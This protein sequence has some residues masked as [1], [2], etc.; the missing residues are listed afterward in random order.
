MHLKL[1]GLTLLGLAL[2]ACATGAAAARSTPTPWK[3]L[4]WSN[5][6]GDA[7]IYSV[8]PNGTGVRRLARSQRWLGFPTWSPDGRKVLFAGG[9]GAFVV[10]PDGTGRRRMPAAGSW[11]PDGRRIVFTNNSDGNNEIY[12]MNVDGSG[13]KN[14]SQSPSSDDF[15]PQWSPDGK[16]VAFVTDRDGNREIYVM[17]ADGSDPQ[18]L[19]HHPLRDGESGQYGPLWSPNGRT[20]MFTTNRDRTEEIYAM[21]ADG[22]N[23]RRL[24]RTLG[25][26]TP[27]SWSPDGRRIAF[28]S[29]PAKPRWA[30][31]VMNADG[32]GMRKVTWALPGRR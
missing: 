12:V 21:D 16:Q 20:I 8:D 1:I 26:D 5:R 13:W 29:E 2:V 4:L 6:E 3:I 11:S 18:N 9:E 28:R 25:Y 22:G 30:F 14:L 19:T 24:T 27:M 17:N 23:V 15:G 32:S 7:G 10:N 31:F